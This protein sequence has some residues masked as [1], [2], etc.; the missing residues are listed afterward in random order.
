MTAR[1]FEAEIR[2]LLIARCFQCHGDVKEPKG[3]LS[4]TSREAVLKGGESGPAAVAGQP[5]ASRL[6]AAVT[7]K[8]DSKCRP[9]VRS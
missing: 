3:G 5:L 4:L 2:P 7:I 9:T 6:M 1:F 8:A